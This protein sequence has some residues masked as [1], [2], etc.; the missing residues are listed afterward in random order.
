MY[1][2]MYLSIYVYM[3]VCIYL[4]MYVCMDSCVNRFSNVIR[5]TTYVYDVVYI[6]VRIG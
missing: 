3:Y 2:F 4:R 1:V 6:G 5:Y